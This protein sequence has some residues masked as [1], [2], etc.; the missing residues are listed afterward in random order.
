MGAKRVAKLDI[1]YDEAKLTDDPDSSG[2]TSLPRSNV[3]R[4]CFKVSPGLAK[5]LR[6]RPLGFGAIEFGYLN[7]AKL[8]SVAELARVWNSVATRKATI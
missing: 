7:S 6:C 4:V 5:W 2:A 1:R 8:A 3:S